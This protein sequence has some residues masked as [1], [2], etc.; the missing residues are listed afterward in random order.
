MAL[1]TA[2]ERDGDIGKAIGVYREIATDF[3]EEMFAATA[4]RKADSL[5]SLGTERND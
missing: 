3:G 5:S 4:A 1:G 2:Y